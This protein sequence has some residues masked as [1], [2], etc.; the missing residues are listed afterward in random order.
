MTTLDEVLQGPVDFIKVDTDGFDFEVLRGGEATIRR[1][2]PILYF[3]LAVDLLPAPRTDLSWLQSLGYR[4][5]M[6]VTQ[7]DKLIG[8]TKDSEQAIAW[9][10]ASGHCDVLVCPE[11][12]P[13]EARLEHLEL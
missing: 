11:G 13:S 4:Q 2:R 6:C 8:I 9:A 7:R 12:S 1:D 10:N 5:L 3:E